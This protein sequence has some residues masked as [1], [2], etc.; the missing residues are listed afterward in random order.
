MNLSKSIAKFVTVLLFMVMFVADFSYAQILTGSIRG[1]V[2]DEEGR[3]LPGVTVELSSTILLGGVH[4]QITS[5][6]GIYRFPNLPPGTYKLVFKMQGF[7]TIERPDIQ[8]T[9]KG[10]MT[11]DVSMKVAPLEE[12]VTIIGQAPIVDVTSSGTSAT[13]NKDFIE[14]LPLPRGSI[15]DSAALSAGLSSSGGYA[16]S[17]NIAAFGSNIESNSFQIDGLDA[18]SSA[19]GYALITPNQEIFSEVEVSGIGQPA[20]YGNFSGAVV[21]TVTKS[22]GNE[23]SGTLAYYGQFQALTDDNNP[24]PDEYYSYHRNKYLDAVFNLGG[25]ILKDRLWFFASVNIRNYDATRWNVDP[26]YH[27]QSTDNNYMFKLSFQIA[28]N[29]KLVGA[30]TYNYYDSPGRADQWTMPSAARGFH[31]EPLPWNVMYTW[32][33]NKNAYFELKSS[34]YKFFELGAGS[35][36]KAGFSEPVRY[37]L[38]TGINSGGTFYPAL[39]NYSR[40]QVSAKLSYF[41][42]NFAGDHEFKI[43]VQYSND[44]DIWAGSYSGGKLY[45][46]WGGEPYLLYTLEPSH[47]G[48]QNVRLGVFFDDSW[49]LGNR[50]SINLG[51]RFD[52]LYGSIP[53]MHYMQGWEDLP[54][55]Y[56]GIKNFLV[57]RLLSPRI[58]FAYTLTSDKKTVLKAH[59]GRYYD[60]MFT[61]NFEW[62]G[63]LVNDFYSYE[64]DGKEWVLFNYVSSEGMWSVPRDMENPVNDSFSISLERELFPNFSIEIVGAYKEWRN[65]VAQKNTTG[66]YEL[67]P[68]VSPDNCQTYMIYN[69]I[70]VGNNTY[71][72]ANIEDH[73]HNYKGISL[74]LKKRYSSNWMLNSSLTWSRSY[75][76]NAISSTSVITQMNV[77]NMFVWVQGQ[78]PN[79][80]INARG[81]MNMDRTWVFKL[82]FGF[83]FPWDILLSLNY[84]AMTGRCYVKRVRVR[85]DQGMRR[86]LAEPR[87]NKNRLDPEKMLDIRIQK[88]FTL[89][90]NVRFSVLAD[91]FN[92]LNDDTIRGWRSYNLWSWNYGQPSSIPAPRRLQIGLKLEF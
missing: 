49:R 27:V 53:P 83:T 20:E 44:K 35:K 85:P 7:Q 68:M 63:P 1:T 77:Q 17:T 82:Q 62:P 67:V 57:W 58:G 54:E 5:E 22:G 60:N 78:D 41:A 50:L 92:L 91:V 79:D 40:F 21:N 72:T 26:K 55:K 64:W 24:D 12:S 34:G 11:V 81:L 31:R 38:L 3:P 66:I 30:L 90:R 19:F 28:K 52:N 86:I 36:G 14:K 32:V 4:S 59:Y 71:I 15:I 25:P 43:G 74:I 80:W 39:T 61:G 42:E 8:V 56:P 70:N 73:G 48:G 87:S 84:S 16:G 75:G 89:Y 65:E 13:F 23:F 88:T 69:Q 47:Y 29:H 51:L 76:L 10:N 46:D 18:T 2:S 33:I 37:D 6:K 45:Y 9:I